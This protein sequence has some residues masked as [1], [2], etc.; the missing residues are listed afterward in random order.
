MTQARVM[1]VG[2]PPSFRNHVAKALEIDVDRVDWLDHAGAIHESLD[3]G[4]P[5]NLV[6]L[7]PNLGDSD[8]LAL[9]EFLGR[10]H[11]TTAVVLVRDRI[12]NGLLPAAVRAGARDV[13][14]LSNGTQELRDALNRAM[15]WSDNLRVAGMGPDNQRRAHAGTTVMVF[16]SKGGTGKTFLS[17]NLAAA[18]AGGG[19]E[20]ALIDL[21]I[22]MGDAFT[23]YGREPDHHIKDLISLGERSNRQAI[24]DAGTSLADNLWG[25]GAP[26][27]PAAEAMYSVPANQVLRTLSNNFA[28]VVVDV[29]ASYSDAVLGAI[30]VSDEICVIATLDVVGIRHLSKGLETLRGIGVSPDRLRVVL[31]RADS[32][33]GITPD[34]VERVLNIKIDDMIPSSRLVPNSLNKGRPVVLDEPRSGVAQSLTT[35]AQRI[36]AKHRPEE[37]LDEAKKRPRRRFS[38]RS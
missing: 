35:L 18:L 29:P 1:A 3:K 19:S 21:D 13:V 33:V 16:S 23:Y 20:T 2:S 14:D 25:F 28:F 24:L 26:P 36:A 10:M 9:I 8:V 27:D 5:A 17:T 37:S 34:D 30:D 12:D 38:G 32:K 7:S 6:V 22:S 4:E 31:N 15:S 11:P